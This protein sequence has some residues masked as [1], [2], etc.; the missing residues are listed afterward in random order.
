M[1]EKLSSSFNDLMEEGISNN[2]DSYTDLST[3]TSSIKEKLKVSSL[4]LFR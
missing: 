1:K 2:C 3:L 4:Q